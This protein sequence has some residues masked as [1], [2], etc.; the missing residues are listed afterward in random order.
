MT[1]KKNIL[2]NKKK[3]AEKERLE[4]Q[5]ASARR[6]LKRALWSLAALAALVIAT[7]FAV[8]P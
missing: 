8:V 7:L 4:H 5:L 6:R 2:K 3:A 1:S